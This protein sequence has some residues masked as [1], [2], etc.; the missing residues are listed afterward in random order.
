M[1]AFAH[2]ADLVDPIKLLYQDLV[3]VLTSKPATTLS[4]VGTRVID[5]DPRCTHGRKH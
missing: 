1:T 4:A 3:S 5:G 2:E